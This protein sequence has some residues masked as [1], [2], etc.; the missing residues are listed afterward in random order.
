MR[1]KIEYITDNK[2][3]QKSVI[4]PHGQWV[5]FEA[6][7]NKLKNKIKVLTGLQSALEE[8]KQIKNGKKRGKSLKEVLD[9]L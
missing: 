9:E 4:I 1:L 3:R 7:Y 6:D 2:G 5:D 8:M